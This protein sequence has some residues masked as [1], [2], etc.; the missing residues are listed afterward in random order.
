MHRDGIAAAILEVVDGGAGGSSMSNEPAKTEELVFSTSLSALPPI[1]LCVLCSAVS[2]AERG[3]VS[4]PATRLGCCIG[5]CT[6]P[7]ATGDMIQVQKNKVLIAFS[8]VT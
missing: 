7:V 6:T 2:H 4:P 1:T 3:A 8:L 5:H